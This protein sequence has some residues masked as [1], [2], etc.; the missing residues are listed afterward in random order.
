[1]PVRNRVDSLMHKQRQ[2]QHSL[3]QLAVPERKVGPGMPGTLASPEL[4]VGE[5]TVGGAD[6]VKS[7]RFV[8]TPYRTKRRVS[9]TYL[10]HVGM[11]YGKQR[12]SS[13]F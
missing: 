3:D 10:V 5:E 9:Y 6:G 11:K 4:N 2:E 7:E 1:M 12:N 13:L 8:D